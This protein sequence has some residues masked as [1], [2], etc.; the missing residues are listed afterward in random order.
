MNNLEKIKLEKKIVKIENDFYYSSERT[1]FLR[2]QYFKQNNKEFVKV[3]KDQDS[4][5]LNNLSKSNCLVKFLPGRKNIKKTTR[6]EIFY[7]NN[8]K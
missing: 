2:G 3:F 5:L 8:F 7:V 1:G 6:V 4:S